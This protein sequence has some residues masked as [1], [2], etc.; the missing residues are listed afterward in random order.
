MGGLKKVWLTND[1]RENYTVSLEY[2]D[3]HSVEVGVKTLRFPANP[4]PGNPLRKVTAISTLSYDDL[5]M[6][7]R[8]IMDIRGSMPHAP[9][10]RDVP[11][12]TCIST[13][14]LGNEAHPIEDVCASM[15]E[16]MASRESTDLADIFSHAAGEIKRLREDLADKVTA[17]ERAYRKEQQHKGEIV[18][19]HQIRRRLQATIKESEA[20]EDALSIK[21]IKEFVWAAEEGS[22]VIQAICKLLRFGLHECYPGSDETNQEALSIEIGN[23]QAA[24]NR[25]TRA[26]MLIPSAMRRGLMQKDNMQIPGI[27]FKPTADTYRT[28]S[29]VPNDSNPPRKEDEDA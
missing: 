4:T 20:D 15:A 10:I 24:V 17:L 21:Q 18:E 9:I 26:N 6:L 7:L 25:L 11:G 3:P 12:V 22:E 29:D 1:G 19:L 27:D 13:P 23:L 5:G 8:A 16:H 2:D 28:R 14:L